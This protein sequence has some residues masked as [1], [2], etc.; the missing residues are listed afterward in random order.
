MP[1]KYHTEIDCALITVLLVVV[2]ML[3]LINIM[4]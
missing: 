1:L 3:V 4:V 2:G